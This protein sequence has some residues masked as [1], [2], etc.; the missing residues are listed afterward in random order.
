MVDKALGYKKGQRGRKKKTAT[1]CVR[2]RSVVD[3]IHYVYTTH[4]TMTDRRGKM[5]YK[6]GKT[7]RWVE[8]KDEKIS[9][10]ITKVSK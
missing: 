5:S 7:K 4:W 3:G 10:I 6:M 8:K 2:S 9:K 1:R